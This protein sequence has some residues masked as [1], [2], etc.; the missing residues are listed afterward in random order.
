MLLAAT[1][2]PQHHHV[3]ENEQD[4]NDDELPNGDVSK[5][6][7]TDD[8]IVDPVEERRTLAE[9]NERL[10]D[11]LKVSYNINRNFFILLRV[12]LYFV[13]YQTQKGT[14]PGFMLKLQDIFCI[15][16]KYF[17]FHLFPVEPFLIDSEATVSI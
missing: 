14:N 6:L 1:T 2:T 16:M 17:I 5:E 13:C 8:N 9:R 15:V 11:Q 3:E 7:D 10:H 4:E 12:K